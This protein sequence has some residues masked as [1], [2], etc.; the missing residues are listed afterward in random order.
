MLGHSERHVLSL[1]CV[2]GEPCVLSPLFLSPLF[3]IPPPL[4][5][6]IPLPSLPLPPKHKYAQRHLK[7][8][9]WWLQPEEF[10]TEVD[11]GELG[12]L[13][14]ASAAAHPGY[15][16]GLL[17]VG[18]DHYL[19]TVRPTSSRRHYFYNTSVNVGACVCCS[20]PGIHAGAS[21]R[22]SGPLLDNGASCVIPWQL[23]SACGP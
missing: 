9:V 6:S 1:G 20:A 21:G 7:H 10:I 8:I 11:A 4:L 18:L 2:F 13:L 5:H 23:N 17:I 12:S 3:S 16:L 15:T 19:T 14:H 22:R